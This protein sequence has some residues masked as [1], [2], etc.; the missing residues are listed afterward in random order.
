MK[1]VNNPI[2]YLQE[3]CLKQKWTVPDYR[4]ETFGS[5]FKCSARI[6]I[7][8]DPITDTGKPNFF[9]YFCFNK[10][11]HFHHEIKITGFGH[12]KK[13]AKINAARNLIALCQNRGLIS[14]FH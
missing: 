5:L 4:I 13:E 3:I 10:F 8:T 1:L 11:Q 9:I 12:T 6:F 2:S 14:K 7:K